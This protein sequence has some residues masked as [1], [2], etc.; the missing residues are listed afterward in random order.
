MDKQLPLIEVNTPE[1]KFN[2]TKCREW[3]HNDNVIAEFL[4]T[5]FDFKYF[6]FLKYNNNGSTTNP[7]R[8]NCIAR[9]RKS[10]AFVLA[11]NYVCYK[12]ISIY[13][14]V[15]NWKGSRQVFSN[16]YLE[17]CDQMKV[18][19]NDKQYR[20]HQMNPD[21]FIDIDG[22]SPGTTWNITNKILT[23]LNDHDVMYSVWCSGSK[24]WHIVIPGHKSIKKEYWIDDQQELNTYYALALDLIEYLGV[25]QWLDLSAY[26]DIR[27]CKQPFSLDGRNMCPIIPLSYEE[28]VKFKEVN[29]TL[30]DEV[31]P[32]FNTDYWL[33]MGI[34]GR[35]MMWNNKGNMVK[36]EQ[37]LDKQLE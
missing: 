10:L 37:F 6:S 35:G 33:L 22:E 31:H 3:Y 2:S 15:D 29:E 27:F 32:F 18:W 1:I 36:L 16:D 19:K 12:P 26:Y 8:W 14:D 4:K 30:K 28:F 13:R 24:G 21:F 25:G 34:R 17:K 11:K 9:N 23:L 7:N 20:K 5:G